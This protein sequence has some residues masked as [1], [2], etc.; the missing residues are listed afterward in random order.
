[1]EKRTFMAK[2]KA[3]AKKV[4]SASKKRVTKRKTVARKKTGAK[5]STKLMQM[6]YSL[7]PQ[8]QA[9]VGAKSATRPQVVKKIWMYIKANKCQDT[10]N[11]RMIIPDKKLAE[12][13]GNKPIDML[14]LAGA[15][16]KH[17]K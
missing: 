2:K 9:V 14:K 15:L 8:L 5:R 3:R 10:K 1:M 7:S 13:I 17:I 4:K 16:N 12:V 11:R 6:A